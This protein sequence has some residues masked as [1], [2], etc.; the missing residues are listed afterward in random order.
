MWDNYYVR[1]S[2]MWDEQ[3]SHLHPHPHPH[4]PQPQP[5][6]NGGGVLYQSCF[7]PYCVFGRS[8]LCVTNRSPSNSKERRND[9]LLE[10]GE[11]LFGTMA[12]QVNIE[13]PVIANEAERLEWAERLVFLSYPPSSEEETEHPWPALVYH[14]VQEFY[15]CGERDL[16]TKIELSQKL[17]KYVL[18]QHQQQLTP[19]QPKPAIR[20]VTFLGRP[21]SEAIF[22][23]DEESQQRAMD[24]FFHLGPVLLDHTL[25]P[26]LF[27]QETLYM[28]FH[29]GL[30]QAIYIATGQNLPVSWVERAQQVWNEYDPYMPE[31]PVHAETDTSAKPSP[32]NSPATNSIAAVSLGTESLVSSSKN[33][34]GHVADASTV[35]TASPG[36]T[37]TA[38]TA[39]TTCSK[40][41]Q[42]TNPA[43]TGIH[44]TPSSLFSSSRSFPSSS[45]PVASQPPPPPLDC[46]P[47]KNQP[48]SVVWNKLMFSGWTMKQRSNQTIDY[49]SPD[50]T[51]YTSLETLQSYVERNYQW[52]NPQPNLRSRVNRPS[53]SSTRRRTQTTHGKNKDD[54][55]DEQQQ[56][57]EEAFHTHRSV[58]HHNDTHEDESSPG[59]RTDE[60]DPT[61]PSEAATAATSPLSSASS[62]TS[63]DVSE[64]TRFAFANVWMKRKQQGWTFCKA[65]HPLQDYWYLF[66]GRNTKDKC[67]Q[68]GV[69]YLVTREQ[70]IDDYRREYQQ[71][72]QRRQQQGLS[73][74]PNKK[75][76]NNHRQP[77]PSQ[78]AR[79]SSKN[80]IKKNN[81]N[82]IKDEGTVLSSNTKS[83][84]IQSGK[85]LEPEHD[86]RPAK[87]SKKKKRKQIPSMVF[88]GCFSQLRQGAVFW[89]G[90][91]R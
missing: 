21:S 87:L 83:R 36:T 71:R 85:L 50:G 12:S 33:P 74:Q 40:T 19:N 86:D 75:A 39:T 59:N 7:Y 34:S 82:N 13:L 72:Q 17:M 2:K 11:A 91:I 47:L 60:A 81:K 53:H 10:R 70:V 69:D 46:S 67:L 27:S 5:K 45:S 41:R 57:P 4:Q 48:W 51:T 58:Q 35:A 31:H 26:R 90:C 30:D 73:S 3:Q 84:S 77:A 61:S 64:D 80:K 52:T 23:T 24:Y 28:D 29:R 37:T 43:I 89:R 32:P 49:R 62:A 42:E 55:D 8:S 56:D 66:P 6:T 54:K 9:F 44:S 25:Q 22:M 79:G 20:V 76:R 15:Q 65:K 88:K 63:S 78:R 16:A 38:T 14:S 1:L 68:E 18:Q